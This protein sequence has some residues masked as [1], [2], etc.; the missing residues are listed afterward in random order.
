[1]ADPLRVLAFDDDGAIVAFL[2]DAF[3]ALHF[4]GRVFASGRQALVA[5]AG[6]GGAAAWTPDVVMMDAS[7][8][9]EDA[10]ETLAALRHRLPGVPVVLSSGLGRE[11]L[12]PGLDVDATLPKPYRLS[13]LR[14]L[15]EAL[16]R[17]ER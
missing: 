1:M 6:E 15:I 11:Q 14:R 16:A 8:P 5:V 17:A 10:A 7:I 4:D 3:T 12:G 9:G 2:R 13:A